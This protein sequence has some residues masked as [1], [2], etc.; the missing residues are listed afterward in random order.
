MSGRV[1]SVEAFEI[2]LPLPR[3]LKLGA[4][5]T[6]HRQYAIVRVR[7][8]EGEVG[9]AVGLTR[10]A[11]IA[12]TVIRTI[13]P[14]LSN[15]NLDNFAQ[16]YSHLVRANVCLG[17]NGVFWR[18]LSLADCA[19]H[20]LMARRAG[21]PLCELLGGKQAAVPCL[22]VGGYPSPDETLESLSD[23]MKQMA[24]LSF[25]GVKIGSSGNFEQD[26][27]RLAAC[28]DASPG[29]PPLMIDLYW[30]CDR[31]EDLLKHALNW[32]PFRMG[33]IED[34]VGFD[35][36]RSS[37]LLA[38]QLPYPVA[39]GDEQCGLRHFER[40]MDDGGVG[41]VRLDATVCGGITGFREIAKAAA[42]RGVKVA[43]HLFSELHTHLA[44]ATN[45]VE[46]VEMFF[47]EAGLDSLDLV[48]KSEMKIVD[49]R[50]MPS[51]APGIG[52]SWDE[53][54]LEHYRRGAHSGRN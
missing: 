48:T 16:T 11:P 1:I 26:T 35:D 22:M 42:G 9:T 47:P 25:A 2:E 53:D 8:D 14:I 44:A 36:F 6:T 34:P 46:S 29:G 40:L 24:K 41:V 32:I 17:T 33:W 27:R 3:P 38:A 45:G 4:I 31:G 18:A 50:L 20:D 7:D 21:L 54:A 43:C 37:A 52:Y 39:I 13:S 10:N 19:V 51:A 30:Q 23:E 5:V 15:S 28:R 12:E 49:G